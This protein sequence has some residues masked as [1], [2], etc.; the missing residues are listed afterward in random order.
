M[1]KGFRF[2]MLLQFAVG[3]MCL[4]VFNTASA[5]GFLNGFILVLSISLVDACYIGLSSLGVSKILKKKSLQKILKLLSA[6][7]LIVFGLN[8]T[9]GALGSSILP[10]VSL[11]STVESQNLFL[12]GIL[13]TASNPLTI[14]FWS[15]VFAGQVVEH[16][17]NKRQILLF[18]TGCVMSTLFF[19]SFVS[20]L[21][22][23]ANTFLSQK[24]ITGMNFIVGVVIIGFGIKILL[25]KR[26]N[27]DN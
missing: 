15:G 2:G 22:S 16:K 25:K 26:L 24:M 11:F 3:P 4:L 19:L 12:K 7:I 27:P 6:V 9:L 5:S 17:F 10:S 14:I 13:L 8:I 20:A 18:G 21:G 23:I 1:W